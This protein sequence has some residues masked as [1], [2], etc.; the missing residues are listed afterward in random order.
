[1]THRHGPQKQRCERESDQRPRVVKLSKRS[2][3]YKNVLQPYSWSNA[4]IRPV[5]VHSGNSDTKMVPNEKQRKT[6]LTST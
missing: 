3:V 2:K 5:L 6:D 1:M 4:I